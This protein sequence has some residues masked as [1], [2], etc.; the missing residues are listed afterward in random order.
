[1]PANVAGRGEETDTQMKMSRRAEGMG[2]RVSHRQGDHGQVHPGE[3]EGLQNGR[4][5]IEEPPD[6]PPGANLCCDLHVTFHNPGCVSSQREGWI[7]A[8]E[9][10]LRC[11]KHTRVF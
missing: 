10:F 3:T 7:S 8:E 4:N 1:M 5:S 6:G 9:Q 2:V 11:V